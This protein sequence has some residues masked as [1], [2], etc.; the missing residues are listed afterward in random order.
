MHVRDLRIQTLDLVVV[1]ALLVAAELAVAFGSA[2][3][4]A[5]ALYAFPLAWTLPFLL[6]RSLPSVA[7]LTMLGALALESFVAQEATESQVALVAVVLA[8]WT[9]GTVPD[10][11]RAIAI[12]IAG[13]LLGCVVVARNP[14]PT[15][16]SEVAF[17]AIVSVLPFAAG[18]LLR[19]R[20]RH[21]DELR[22]RAVE[23]E[24]ERE[25][26]A[27]VAV[28][29]ER[30]RIAREL[31]DVVGHAVGVMTVQAGA[32]R[33]LLDSEPDRARQSLLAVEAAGR[34]ALAEMRRLLA[35]LRTDGES[36]EL[37]PQPGL[38][39]LPELVRQVRDAGLPVDL[40]VDGQAASLS[41]GLDLAAYRI[42]Q[43]ALTNVRKHAGDAATHVQVRYV[44]DRLELAVENEGP[45]LG[46]GAPENGHG[47]VGMRERVALYGGEVE[48]G[49]RAEGGFAVRIR[50]PVVQ[51]AQ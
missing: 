20:E 30:A 15:G 44:L 1:G 38:S 25:E 10:R 27:R 35:V 40:V 22:R 18:M 32:A 28:E 12:G 49:P 42:V 26:R 16:A 4:P 43:E 7:A 34:Q 24:H 3:G 6:H 17:V 13:V 21:T 19:S 47:L 14:G 33:L 48:A 31:H 41:P 46:P 23:L 11:G 2:D 39:D 37:V 51:E 45:A 9:A 50:F 5:A 36:H 29:E 8:F